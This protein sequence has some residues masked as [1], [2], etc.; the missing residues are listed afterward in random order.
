MID[1]KYIHKSKTLPFNI[2]GGVSIRGESIIFNWTSDNKNDVVKLAEDCSGSFNKDG[3]RY[4]YGYEYTEGSKRADRKVFRQ[5]LKSLAPTS[6]ELYDSNIDEF[7]E[8]AVLRLDERYSLDNFGATVHV[9]SPK[10]PALTDIM[11]GYLWDCMHNADFD[12]E[13]VKEAYKNVQFNKNKAI[14]ALVDS[15]KSRHM[16]TRQVERTAL[17]FEQLKKENKLFQMKAFVP[18]ELRDGFTHFLKFKTEEERKAY[19]TLQGTNVLIFDDFLTSG[20]TIKEVIR[21]LKAIHDKNTLTVFVLV[22][23]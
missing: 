3:I 13:L 1:M 8:R 22:K 5:Y 11:R 17:K 4:I 6:E 16:A 23:Q 2:Y 10:I 19:E 21:Y 9:E 20:A 7:I 18:R 14:Q 12:F 15:G